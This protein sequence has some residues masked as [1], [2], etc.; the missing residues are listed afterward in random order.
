MIEET[1]LMDTGALIALFNVSDPAHLA[2]ASLAK[3]LPLGKVY[4]CW[5]VLT[6][7]AYLLRKYPAQRD[8]LFSAVSY[9]DYQLLSLDSS[10]L[11]AIQQLIATYDDQQVDLADAALVHLANREGIEVVCTTDRR[12][13]TIYRL[14]NGR[15]FR[16]LPENDSVR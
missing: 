4:T 2:C 16:L 14:A 8:A 7:A 9:G 3:V 11:T 10:D 6:E 5:P 1:V 12:H 15:F 13:F